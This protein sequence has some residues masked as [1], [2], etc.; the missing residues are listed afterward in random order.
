[1]DWGEKIRLIGAN[2]E[3]RRRKG[4]RLGQVTSLSSLVLMVALGG[5]YPHVMT[6][7]DFTQ[8]SLTPQPRLNMGQ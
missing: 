6:S 8:V 2:L 7:Q 3:G 5:S 1:M 4:S